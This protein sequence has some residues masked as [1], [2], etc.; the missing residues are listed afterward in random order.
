RFRF[1]VTARGKDKRKETVVD[2]LLVDQY[3]EPAD[4]G[5]YL[6]PSAETLLHTHLYNK[7]NAGGC[8]HVHPEH[9]NVFSALDGDQT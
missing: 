9:N 3:G 7:S 2:F 5:H 1:L 6:K 8:L 4:S